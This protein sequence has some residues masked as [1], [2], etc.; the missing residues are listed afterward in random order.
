M[1]EECFVNVRVKSDNHLIKGD[2]DNGM[3]SSSNTLQED[4]VTADGIS[5]PFDVSSANSASLPAS[6]IQPEVT[7]PNPMPPMPGFM[8]AL[9][10][11]ILL[12]IFSFFEPRELLLTVAP[13]CRLWHELANDP[14]CWQSLTFCLENENVT[15]DFKV[16]LRKVFEKSPLLHSL[17]IYEEQNARFPLTAA[18]LACC[19]KYCHKV[20]NLHLHF[21]SNLDFEMITKLSMVSTADGIE[22]RWTRTA[23]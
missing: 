19:A 10:P 3:M 15:S 22:Y 11:E 4:A 9:P 2:L 6:D 14:I 13:V 12:H 5:S 16:F 23:G 18:D 8:D 21:I 1:S 7:H 17:E 20:V